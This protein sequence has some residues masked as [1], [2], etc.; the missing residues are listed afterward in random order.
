MA[1]VG[2]YAPIPG[3][4]F[5]VGGVPAV[6]YQLFTYLAGT[7][8]KVSTYTN[9]A[10]SSANTNPIVLGADARPTIF[11]TPG[12]SYKFV[13]APPTDSDPPVSPIFTRDNVAAVP[14]GATA[15]NAEIT[16]TAGE[17]LTANDAVYLSDGTGGTTAGRWYKTD[18]DA[19]A[20]SNGAQATGFAVDS[21]SIG[22]TGT[23]RR[24]GQVTGLSGLS[25]GSLYYASATGGAITAT[26]PTFARI[27][28]QA[29]SATVLTIVPSLPDA[30]ATIAG[31]ITATGNQAIAG[32][33]Q[34][35]G[36]WTFTLPPIGIPERYR[37][38]ADLVKNASVV[39]ANATDLA[40]AI[41]AS[42]EV[43]F[44][45]I[46]RVTSVAGAGA[47]YTFT[48]PAA[49]TEVMFGVVGSHGN[50]AGGTAAAVAFAAVISAATISGGLASQHIISGVVRN[51]ANAG[52]VQLQFCQAASNA[53][54]STLYAGSYLI[55]QRS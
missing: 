14:S 39:M 43:H 24:L 50:F 45:A 30:S 46:L 54:D 19:V 26:P 16:G 15:Q 3:E 34:P 12:V 25:P 36:Q 32:A 42:E 22:S 47:A 8:T 49:P 53:S 5:E 44:Q 6:G 4:V 35:S 52:T 51:G 38:T 7:A 37:K 29:D 17:S 11:L 18:A 41:A 40:F 55:V 21:I 20:S 10:L 2:T 28:G 1:A 9:V 27:L 33:K 48:G 13:L 23:I 31:Q